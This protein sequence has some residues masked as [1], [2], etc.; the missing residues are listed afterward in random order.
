MVYCIGYDLNSPGKNYTPLIEQIKSYGIWWHHLDST[1]FI[2]SNKTASQIRDHLV[3][4][5]DNT[6][7]LLV[8]KVGDSWAGRGFSKRGYDWLH[9]NWKK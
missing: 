2:V 5:I 3:E 4:Y 1:W 7:E 6:D 9:N 8:F